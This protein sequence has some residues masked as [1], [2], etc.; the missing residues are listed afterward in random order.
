MTSILDAPIAHDAP[1]ADILDR[2]ADIIAENGRH[3]GNYW[4]FAG[5]IGWQPTMACCAAGAIGIA[6]GWTGIR[7]IEEHVVPCVIL[8]SDQPPHPAFTAVMTHLH[9]DC[10]N[11]VFRW[12]D[13]HQAEEIAAVM[14]ECAA[15]LRA[16]AGVLV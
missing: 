12:S 15:D 4:E 9:L 1:P 7:D 2:A 10:V 8:G 16:Q 6:L 5:D 14:R 11:H 3:I 13:E